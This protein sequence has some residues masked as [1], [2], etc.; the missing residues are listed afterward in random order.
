MA[1]YTHLDLNDVTLF[2]QNYSLGHVLAL[3]PI[4]E[5]IEN[6]NYFLDTS[7]GRYVLTL[8][9]KRTNPEDLPYFLAFTQHLSQKGIS[10]PA[11]MM[12]I[13]GTVLGTIKGK[14]ATIISF[15]SGKSILNPTS[16]SCYAAGQ[17]FAKIHL[18]SQDFP[19]RRKNTLSLAGWQDLFTKCQETADNVQARLA[20]FIRDELDFLQKNWRTDLPM[21]TIHA[22][23][24]TDNV[25]FEHPDQV[26]GVIDFYFSCYDALVYELAICLNAW[27]CDQAGKID[28]EKFDALLKGYTEV[29]SLSPQEQDSLTIMLRGA[30]MRFLLTRLHDTLFPALDAIVTPK[31]PLQ[32]VA[33]LK[34]HQGSVL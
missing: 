2:L 23:L 31:N 16:K 30:A 24:F 5:G 26:A 20:D 18:A 32:Y 21:G 33:I 6:T 14:Q 29:R 22:D 7:M 13:D 4:A 34:Y 25:F 19:M 17:Y 11:P 8:F 28:Q 27:T 1:V 3:T 10:C 15:L 12:R 9:E